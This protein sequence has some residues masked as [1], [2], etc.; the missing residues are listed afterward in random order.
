MSSPVPPLGV[1]S[2][3]LNGEVLELTDE[4]GAMLTQGD[5]DCLGP[6]VTW[7]IPHLPIQSPFCKAKD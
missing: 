3:F 7:Q 6:R 4:E 1:D 2:Y 5:K